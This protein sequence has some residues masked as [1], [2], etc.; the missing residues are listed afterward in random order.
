[1]ADGEAAAEAPDAGGLDAVA[2]GER[3]FR[4]GEA[5]VGI[6]G[7]ELAGDGFPDHQR[8]PSRKGRK[9]CFF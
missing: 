9:R 7:D 3:R 8:R 4:V 2:Q 5:G 6:A 1:M